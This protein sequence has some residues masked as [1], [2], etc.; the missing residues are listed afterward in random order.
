LQAY[1]CVSHWVISA[2]RD[3]I[4]GFL[5][6]DM[7]LLA[8][9]ISAASPCV[10]GASVITRE[11]NRAWRRCPIRPPDTVTVI[12]SIATGIVV[13]FA[14]RWCRVRRWVATAS[15]VE[16]R[17]RGPLDYRRPIE[18]RACCC[19]V[20]AAEALVHVLPHTAANR[21]ASPSQVGIGGPRQLA[22]VWRQVLPAAL[23]QVQAGCGPVRSTLLHETFGGLGHLRS[24]IDFH[25]RAASY[26]ARS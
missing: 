7:L 21:F 17:E 12:P 10:P 5:R 13:G 1:S 8:A 18:I 19:R 6:C 16:L 20:Q 9:S 3:L 14:V 22:D 15:V 4:G 24:G 26:S 23:I 2:T 11:I 25:D